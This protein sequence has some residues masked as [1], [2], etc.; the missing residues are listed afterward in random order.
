MARTT[1][2][3]ST[4]LIDSLITAHIVEKNTTPRTLLMCT[5]QDAT[6]RSVICWP[7]KICSREFC[8]KFNG[9]FEAWSKIPTDAFHFQAMSNLV[10]GKWKK[11]CLFASCATKHVL[12][13]KTFSITL[14]ISIA[15]GTTSAKCVPK[16][17]NLET[18]YRSIATG[19]TKKA[20]PLF[21]SWA[22][23][24][25]PFREEFLDENKLVP[26]ELFC[27]AGRQ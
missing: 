10:C 7:G 14:K 5:F 6:K 12:G 16:S 26:F 19:T 24:L 17:S 4:S 1:W 3:Q 21:K 8:H 11:I 23:F 15:Q 18:R 25:S 20:F 9:H 13:S 2:K 22:H 27:F